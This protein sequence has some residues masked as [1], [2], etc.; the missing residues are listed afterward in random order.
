[1]TTG[2]NLTLAQPRRAKGKT[3]SRMDKE[4]DMLNSGPLGIER[5]VYNVAL[6]F[7][8]KH[9]NMTHEQAMIAALGYCDR[10]YGNV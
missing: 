2:N 7:R 8:E 1:M 6:D 4:L 10:T 3:L 9:P 5:L